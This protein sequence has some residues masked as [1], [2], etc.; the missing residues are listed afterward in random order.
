MPRS[1]RPSSTTAS[2]RGG[3]G[4]CMPC[5]RRRGCTRRMLGTAICSSSSPPG[6]RP[7]YVP[8]WA[9]LNVGANPQ[10][11][12]CPVPAELSPF[13]PAGCLPL[14]GCFGSWASSRNTAWPAGWRSRRTSSRASHPAAKVG[15]G[16]RGR[17]PPQ[18]THTCPTLLYVPPGL[19][20]SDC[21]Q[22]LNNVCS[23]CM[24]PLSYKD[25]GD[26]EM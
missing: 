4:W 11:W 3:Q 17:S 9:S 5:A 15:S 7:R 8:R 21:H 22:A 12:L 19:Y 26:E 13:L 18:H 10:G 1:G 14:A 16:R 20:C 24:G 23:I 25:M 6:K 2:W